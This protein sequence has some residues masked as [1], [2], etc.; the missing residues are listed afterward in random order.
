[1]EEP[2]TTAVAL[3]N[4]AHS[5]AQSAVTL[6]D[7]QT[8][9]THWNAP[10]YF[11]YFHAIELYLKALLV[12]F[13]HDLEDLRKTYGHRVRPLAELCQ[14]QGL[15]LSLDAEQAI[16]L[17]SDTD[18]VITSRYIRVGNHKRLPFSVYY[19]MCLSLHEQVGWK[20]YQDSGVTRRPVL[21][22]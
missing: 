12:S 7:N 17:M 13:G 11:L 18:N 20:V 5:Y 19:E 3:F 16:D 2:K 22:R 21:K 10:V 15:Q 8:E 14:K 1:M 9:A 6:E 4:Y